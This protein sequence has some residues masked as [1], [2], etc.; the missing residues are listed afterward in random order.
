[1]VMTLYGFSIEPMIRGYHEYKFVWDNPFVGEDLLCEWEVGNSHNTHAVVVKKVIDGNLTVVG[2]VPRR[3]SSI[4][5]TFLRRGGTINGTVDVSRRYSSDIPQRGFE[6]P[7]VLTFT[8]Q[9][10]VKDKRLLK[11][12]K[13]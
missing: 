8:A 2:H 6:I 10:S 3:L 12:L 4:C 7:C 9:S 11:K 13:I 5:S 1:M